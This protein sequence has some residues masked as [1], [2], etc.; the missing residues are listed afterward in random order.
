MTAGQGIANWAAA[1]LHTSS[2]SAL[3]R[4]EAGLLLSPSS[5]EA[6]EAA[7]CAARARVM[8]IPSSSSS[9]DMRSKVPSLFWSPILASW[10]A[11]GETRQLSGV[12]TTKA[13]RKLAGVLTLG[14]RT[15]M[16]G[17]REL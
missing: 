6:M 10:C 12:L 13:E 4:G 5:Q 9:S 15:A 14:A 16:A 2:M 17:H 3:G 8:K 7:S 11:S 1:Y